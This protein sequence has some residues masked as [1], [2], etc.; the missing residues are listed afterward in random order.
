MQYYYLE[1]H[2]SVN[3]YIMMCM[4]NWEN[5]LKTWHLSVDKARW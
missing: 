1:S 4:W 3:A 5:M 2:V